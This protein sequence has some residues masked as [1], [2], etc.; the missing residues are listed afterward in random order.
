V[1]ER[2]TRRRSTNSIPGALASHFGVASTRRNSA[3]RKTERSSPPA[4]GRCSMKAAHA[5]IRLL[6]R[7]RMIK[8]AA[9]PQHARELV[10]ARLPDSGNRGTTYC[11]MTTLNESSG[12]SSF[13]GSMTARP[14]RS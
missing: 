7:V 2:G 8:F 3:V 12:N 10:G 4:A 9:R 11:A 13:F 6:T 1:A 14:R 5:G